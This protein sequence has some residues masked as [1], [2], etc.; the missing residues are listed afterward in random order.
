MRLLRRA[1]EHL[2]EDPLAEKLLQGEFQ[3]KDTILVNVVEVD[4][5][6]KLQFD[7]KSS[8]AAPELA[9][10]VKAGG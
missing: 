9:T 3:G 1:I 4:G 10:S 5:E 8:A 2:A 7:S 6:K